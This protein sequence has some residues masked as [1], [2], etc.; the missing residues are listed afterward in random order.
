MRDSILKTIN[1]L[2]EQ[3]EAISPEEKKK[4][5]RKLEREHRE[6]WVFIGGLGG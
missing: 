3:I 1:E 6:F 5:L 4:L 2:R